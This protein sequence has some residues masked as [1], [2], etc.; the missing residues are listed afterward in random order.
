MIDPHPHPRFVLG[1][2][3]G[4]TTMKAAIVDVATGAADTPIVV[5]ESPGDPDS[6][7]GAVGRLSQQ[8]EWAGP[9][10]CA[11]PGVVRESQLFRGTNLSP[12]WAGVDLH[13]RFVEA[14]G[15]A[16]VLLNDADAA[17]LAE[18]RFGTFHHDELAILLTFGTG[19]GS[20]LLARG[21][22]VPNSELGELAIDGI[23]F[24]AVGSARAIHR[25]RLS[26]V[27]WAALV[28]PYFAALHAL[29][30]PARWI[31][32]G[33]L[34]DRFEEYFGPLQLDAPVVPATFRSGAGIV[35]A[36]LAAAII[37]DG[38]M[39]GRSVAGGTQ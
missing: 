5:E 27:S 25:S 15:S 36:A 8:L 39:D 18:A 11:L 35:S 1:I 38:D 32:A 17:G 12:V 3:M 20:A 33:G 19:I 22:L 34:T 23:K 6:L 21:R 26:A 7:V 9:V 31:I 30:S 2:D 24:E 37:H 29:L 16:P 14:L 10:G 4:A 13:R 28:Q